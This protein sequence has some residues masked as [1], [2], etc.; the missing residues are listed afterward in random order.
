MQHALIQHHPQ[1]RRRRA[2]GIR[3]A[4][5]SDV[6]RGCAGSLAP[7]RKKIVGT[8]IAVMSASGMPG[9]VCP[10]VGGA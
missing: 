5:A 1:Q 7:L 6:A 9:I 2:P 3:E 8:E 4:S 10:A